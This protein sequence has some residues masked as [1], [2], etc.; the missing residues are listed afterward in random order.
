MTGGWERYAGALAEV[1]AARAAVTTGHHGLAR[2]RAERLARLHELD[3]GL[4][5]RQERL[6]ALAAGVRAPLAADQLAALPVPPMP[7][8]QADADAR[9]R[10]AAADAALAQARRVARLPQL[11]PQWSSQLARCA[12][13]YA[14][15]TIPAVMLVSL[16]FQVKDNQPLL[17]WFAVGWPLIT[18]IG[19]AAVIGRVSLPRWPPDEAERLATRPQPVRR[20]PWLGVL[21]A[22]AGALG[23][24]WVLEHLAAA[25]G[26]G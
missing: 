20:H 17:L 25:V 16:T 6:Q 22:W 8:P 9:G 18:A 23:A 11:L 5:A 14:G 1:H 13:V 3:A 10:S 24:Q 26:A 19:G 2:R 4:R 21:I 7:W 12:V 15:F